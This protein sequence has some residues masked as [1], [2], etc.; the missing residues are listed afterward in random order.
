MKQVET[1]FCMKQFKPAIAVLAFLVV[2]VLAWTVFHMAGR[3]KSRARMDFTLTAATAPAVKPIEVKD[4]MLHAYWGNCSNC[5]VTTNAGK[6]VSRVMTGP[7][8]SINQKM[9]HKYWGNCLL[10]HQVTDGLKQQKNAVKTAAFNRLTTHSLGLEVQSVSGV[11]M[12]RMGLSN[13]DGAL[14]LNVAH[15]S[16]AAKAGL[17]RGDEILF[18]G[19]TRIENAADFQTAMNMAEPGKSLKFKITRGKKSRNLFVKVPDYHK[20]GTQAVAPMYQYQRNPQVFYQGGR[21]NQPYTAQA[22]FRQGQ[23]VPPLH[24]NRMN[25]QAGGQWNQPYAGQAPL[26]QGQAVRPLHRNW[27]NYQAGGRWNQ[28]Y[29]VQAPQGQA[30]QAG[31]TVNAPVAVA[32]LNPRL[33]CLVSPR[34]E[35]SPYFVVFDPNKQN[36][37]IVANPNVND[38]TGRGVQTGQFMVD[39]GAGNVIAGSYSQNALRTLNTLKVNAYSG[40]TGTVQGA[41]NALYAGKFTPVNTGDAARQGARAAGT[42][43]II[44]NTQRTRVIY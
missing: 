41:I 4:K 20:G 30:R 34:F 12:R 25:Y 17:K 14:I 23:A 7:P 6:P 8:I 22:P 3:H 9:T 21:W 39:L 33:N 24:R 15:S 10:C 31:A 29:A 13:E 42:P 16:P 5:H 26:G 18:V 1:D 19:K 44:G 43:P 27:M 11:M 37:R 2:I 32:V 35:A 28:P 38:A 40:V 36:Y